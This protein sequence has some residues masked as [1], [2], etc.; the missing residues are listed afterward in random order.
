M[1]VTPIENYQRRATDS[2]P[3]GPNGPSNADLWKVLSEIQRQLDIVIAKQADHATAFVTNDIGKP[4]LEG[5]RLYHAR[6]IKSAEQMAQYK[7]GLTKTIAEWAVKG[8]L[9]LTGLAL[10][11][12]VSQKIM[13]HL[14]K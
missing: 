9:A 7:T 10:L 2:A 3:G 5:H 6:S 14:P 12:L 1:S 8:F 11:N 13:E 4:D